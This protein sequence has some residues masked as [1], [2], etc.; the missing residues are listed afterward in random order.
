M[1]STQKAESNKKDLDTSGQTL[2]ASI[3]SWLSDGHLESLYLEGTDSQINAIKNAMIA[4]KDFQNELYSPTA[5]LKTLSEK[6]ET[7]TL[8][9][10]TFKQELGISWLL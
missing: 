3:A 5:T 1:A 8:A 10:A 4:S 6:L 9:A 2:F 7:K